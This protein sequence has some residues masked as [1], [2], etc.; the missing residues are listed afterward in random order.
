MRNKTIDGD[1]QSAG[2]EEKPL[3]YLLARLY[4][5]RCRYF[6]IELKPLGIG[7][8]S[9]PFLMTVWQHGSITQNEL[10]SVLDTDKA[11]TARAVRRLVDMGFMQRIRNP[12][13]RRA[14]IVR[15]TPKGLKALPEVKNVLQSWNAILNDSMDENEYK[16]AHSL[17]SSMLLNACDKI[18]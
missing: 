9:L 1:L 18:T 10:S 12:E 11:N 4:W 14:N 8:G 5:R 15:L 16:I 2:Y 6:D 3:G 13:D 7:H 17:L